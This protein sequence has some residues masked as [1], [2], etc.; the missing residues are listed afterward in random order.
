MEIAVWDKQYASRA[1][2]L[3]IIYSEKEFRYRLSNSPEESL[4]HIFCL[5]KPQGVFSYEERKQLLT[6]IIEKHHI[7]APA[8]FGKL[9]SSGSQTTTEISKPKWNIIE[10][11]QIEVYDKEFW[12][13][14]EFLLQLYIDNILPCYKDWHFVF[15]ELQGIEQVSKVSE[16]CSSQIDLFN[17][18]DRLL[19]CKDLAQYICNSRKFGRDT[20]ERLDIIEKL[21]VSL[22][23]NTPKQYAHYF[24]YHFDGL[25]PIPFEEGSYSYEKER[26]QLYKFQKEKIIEMISVFG[27]ESVTEII[28]LVE[29]VFA[30]ANIIAD[31]LMNFNPDW[32]YI[33][34]LKSIN[35]S[36]SSYIITALFRQTGAQ[37]ITE[38]KKTLTSEQFG[39]MLSCLPINEE[40][41]NIVNDIRDEKGKKIYWENV[42]INV[43]DDSKTLWVNQVV[44]SL[45]KYRRPYSAIDCLAYSKWNEPEIILEI[46]KSALVQQPEPEPSGLTLA[47]V[48]SYDIQKMF[49]KLYSNPCVSEYEVAKMELSYLRVFE[50]GFEPKCLTNQILSS[51]EIYF[52]LLTAVFRSDTDEIT[53]K[54]SKQTHF[55]EI[56]YTALERVHRIPGYSVCDHSID[57]TKFYKWIEATNALAKSNKYTRSHDTVLGKILS[58]SPDGKDGI[59]PAKCVR[60]IFEKAHSDTLENSFIIGKQNQRGVHTLTAG[61]E[62]KRIAEQYKLQAD[63]I[64]VAYPI[65]ASILMRICDDYLEE[66]KRDQ[67]RELKGF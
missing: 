54:S 13:I 63:K 45:I 44:Q 24:S 23:P 49:E 3:L 30:F 39:W 55:A 65:T 56:A 42:S 7:I 36:L 14:R 21:Y 4:Y 29:D 16:K 22:L 48:G 17:E 5:W 47:Q 53:T 6:E 41:T 46:L 11:S 58:Y 12:E 60:E 2:K 20:P 61:K 10:N 32:D 15:S 64:Q 59:W 31:V 26:A 57:E 19:L 40:I 50:L 33:I 43:M 18:Y 52:E 1:V 62:E 38:A 27:K 9:L 8:I 67:A 51:P 25:Y 28:P 66:S 37:M 35:C 34:C